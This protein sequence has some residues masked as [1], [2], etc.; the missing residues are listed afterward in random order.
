MFNKRVSLV[1]FV[2]IVSHS[3]VSAQG[4]EVTN[5]SS[6][7]P[8]PDFNSIDHA[9]PQRY[10]ELY[11]CM[12]D[13]NTIQAI[14]AA[15]EKDTAIQTLGAIELWIQDHLRYDSSAAYEWHN[16]DEMIRRGIYG[17]C[18]DRALVFGTLAR[19]CGIPS[20]WVKTMNNDWI[21]DF[22]ILGDKTYGWRGHVFLEMYIDNQWMLLDADTMKLYEAY[23]PTSHFFPGNRY[24]YDKGDNPYDMVLSLRWD[25]WKQQTSL[26]FKDFDI[27]N[28]PG[29]GAG[30][31]ISALSVYICARGPVYAWIEEHCKELGYHVPKSFDACYFE[32]YRPLFTGHHLVLTCI[33]DHI[34]LPAPYYAQYLPLP[35]DE[36]LNNVDTEQYGILRKVL[37]DQ[38]QVTLLFGKDENALKL[39]IEDLS[40]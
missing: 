2:L 10:L 7:I 29:F 3:V 27:C 28:L 11:A 39:A 14:A 13:P 21:Y 33:G 6:S 22:H 23:D 30:R 8:W 24:A 5:T 36:I 15:V 37:P 18:A 40:F 1:V 19:A 12:G 34:E 26:Y 20:V 32:S 35:L 17:S 16:I 31:D 38:T 9:Q 25:L 4:S